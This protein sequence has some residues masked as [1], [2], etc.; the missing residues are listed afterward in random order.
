MGHED[1]SKASAAMFTH[2][3]FLPANNMENAAEQVSSD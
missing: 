1:I 3:Y 2:N